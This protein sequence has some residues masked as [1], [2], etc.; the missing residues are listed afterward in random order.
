MITCIR[1]QWIRRNEEQEELEQ[2]EQEQAENN[3][4][5]S[6]LS[7]KNKKLDAFF[8]PCTRKN[9]LARDYRWESNEIPE[10]KEQEELE[11]D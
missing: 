6:Y 7:H 11:Q 8:I 9:K 10:I 2:E 3:K 5:Q 1:K 4:N